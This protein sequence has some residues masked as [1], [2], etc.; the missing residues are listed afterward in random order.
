MPKSMLRGTPRE[1][2]ESALR[3]LEKIPRTG[4]HRSELL[5]ETGRAHQHLGGYFTGLDRDLPRAIRHHDAALQALGERA[6]LNPGDAVAR[7]NFADQ[8]VMKA[9]AQNMARDGAGALQSTDRALEMLTEL[10]AADPKNVEAQHDLAFAHGERGRALA[11]LGRFA[12]AIRA[13]DAAVAIHER[14]IAADPS[15]QEERRDLAR[16]RG[17]RGSAAKGENSLY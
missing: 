3:I 8:F 6:R 13:Y 14:R 9:T 11:R 7:R 10:A 4:P 2:Y 15:N 17:L 5:M 16:I 12:E 1:A